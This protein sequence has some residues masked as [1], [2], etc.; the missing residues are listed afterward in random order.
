MLHPLLDT[1]MP[2]KRLAVP[3]VPDFTPSRDLD[4][5]LDFG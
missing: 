1:L 4:L 2:K 3:T 5:G